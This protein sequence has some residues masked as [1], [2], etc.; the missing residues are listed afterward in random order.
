MS[1]KAEKETNLTCGGL[2]THDEESRFSFCATIRLWKKMRQSVKLLTEIYE[3]APN[4]NRYKYN[5]ILGQD[6]CGLI[7]SLAL[8][9]IEANSMQ[10]VVFK[11]VTGSQQYSGFYSLKQIS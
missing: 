8:V 3:Y 11:L 2:E 10:M 9:S 1:I 6:K 7:D 4:R 5:Y